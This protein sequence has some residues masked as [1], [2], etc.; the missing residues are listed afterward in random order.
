MEP[1]ANPKAVSLNEASI[2]QVNFLDGDELLLGF[3]NGATV[4][5][6]MQAFKEFVLLHAKDNITYPDGTTS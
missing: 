1:G 3:S 6:P 4:R 5:I 2:T